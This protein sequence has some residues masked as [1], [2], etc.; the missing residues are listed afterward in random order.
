MHLAI[1]VKMFVVVRV[2]VCVWIVGAHLV[3]GKC[4]QFGAIYRRI[5]N[6]CYK[7]VRWFIIKIDDQNRAEEKLEKATAIPKSNAPAK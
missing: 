5:D 4:I 7:R 6:D 3:S 2:C 1:I